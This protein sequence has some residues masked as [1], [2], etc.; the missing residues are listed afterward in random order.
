MIGNFLHGMPVIFRSP[1]PILV[2]DRGMPVIHQLLK[3]FLI[4]T[5]EFFPSTKAEMGCISPQLTPQRASVSSGIAR[6]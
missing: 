1:L 3:E 2:P 4:S 6:G 5:H